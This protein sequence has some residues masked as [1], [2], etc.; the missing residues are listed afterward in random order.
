MSNP[1]SRAVRGVAASSR[2]LVVLPEEAE[3][4][5]EIPVFDERSRSKHWRARNTELR[6]KAY[7]VGALLGVRSGVLKIAK[8][9]TEPRAGECGALSTLSDHAFVLIARLNVLSAHFMDLVDVDIASVLDKLAQDEPLIEELAQRLD[10][11]DQP[12]LAKALREALSPER[13][14]VAAAT[15]ALFAELSE[16]AAALLSLKCQIAT[17]VQG[18]APGEWPP[19]GEPSTA[20][21]KTQPSSRKRAGR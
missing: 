8:A 21:G 9:T 15:G 16:C 4:T 11:A 13:F 6:L 19:S 3:V 14:R 7:E 12:E 18:E 5:V 20:P 2:A 1:S 17:H 10:A